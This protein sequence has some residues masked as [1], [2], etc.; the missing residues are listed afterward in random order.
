MVALALCDVTDLAAPSS[1]IIA[2]IDLDMSRKKILLILHQAK[3]DPGRVGEVLRSLGFELD[4]RIPAIGHELP[5]DP[6]E[7]HGAVIFGGPMSANDDHEDYIRSETSYVE[8]ALAAEIPYLGICLGAQIMARTLGGKVKRHPDGLMEIGYYKIEPTKAGAAY[9]DKHLHAYQWHKEGFDLPEGCQLLAGG[10]YFPNQAYR[11]GKY[12]YGIQ[13]HPE[14]T[15]AMNRKWLH[16]ASHMLVEPGAQ[17][18]QDQL[19]CRQLYDM[20]MN[21]WTWR[22]LRH[23]TDLNKAGETG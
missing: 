19:R 8:R 2:G 10:D 16:K 21:D 14:V 17:S 6:T 20:E 1:H 15:E 5:T 7:H 13:F 9:F 23:W 4:I 3:S 18:A 22:F 12:A 11:Y